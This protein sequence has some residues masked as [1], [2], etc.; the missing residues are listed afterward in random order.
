MV[1]DCCAEGLVLEETGEESLAAVAAGEAVVDMAAVVVMPSQ[2]KDG[3]TGALTGGPH[4]RK[5]YSLE[6]MRALDLFVHHSG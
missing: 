1:S 4:T 3:R 6:A 5:M 2:T